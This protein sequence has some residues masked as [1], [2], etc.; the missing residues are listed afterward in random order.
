MKNWEKEGKNPITDPSSNWIPTIPF[1]GRVNEMI[2]EKW[3]L[4]YHF[5]AGVLKDP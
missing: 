2:V 1:F 3:I 5:K 4:E